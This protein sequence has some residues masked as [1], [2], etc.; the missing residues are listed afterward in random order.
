MF[1]IQNFNSSDS[2]N[3]WQNAILQNNVNHIFAYKKT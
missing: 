1:S 3:T 2:V